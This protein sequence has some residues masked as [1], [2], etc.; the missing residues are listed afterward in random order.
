MQAVKEHLLKIVAICGKPTPQE[1]QGS[2]RGLEF[3]QN[4]LSRC[5]QPKI[6]LKML[7]ANASPEALDL[8]SKMLQWSPEKRITPEAA[9]RHPYLKGNSY[10]DTNNCD[11]EFQIK[12]VLHGRTITDRKESDKWKLSQWKRCMKELLIEWAPE[13]K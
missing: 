2:E 12:L 10:I 13:L 1:I 6:P 8:L 5:N 3:F 9:L 4:L 7:F 11:E